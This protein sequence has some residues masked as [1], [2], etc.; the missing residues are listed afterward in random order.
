MTEQEAVYCLK[1]ESER[2]PHVCEECPLYGQ[3]GCDHCYDDANDVAIKAL[4]EIQQYRALGTVEE[5]RV[6]RDKQ[7]AKKPKHQKIEYG[8]HKWKRKRNGEIDDFAWDYQYCNG[9]VC[10]VCGDTYCVH[11]NPDY[12]N[13]EDCV[14][15]D[16]FCPNCN[17]KVGYTFSHCARCNQKLDRSNEDDKKL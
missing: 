14:T 9:V 6:A 4:E 3:T 12:D 10:E 2:Y 16:W 8:K 1:A 15:E 11:C 5:L 7:V 17:E 13:L